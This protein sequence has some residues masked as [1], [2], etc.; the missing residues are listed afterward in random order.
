M[1]VG[2]LFFYKTKLSSFNSARRLI[3]LLINKMR[4]ASRPKVNQSIEIDH[5][6]Q[7]YTL[8]LRYFDWAIFQAH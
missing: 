3:A 2:S 7:I 8:A 6:M 1:R 4:T 5:A